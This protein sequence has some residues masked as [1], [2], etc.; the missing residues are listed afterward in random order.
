MKWENYYKIL[1]S[2]LLFKKKFKNFNV[3]ITN[4]EIKL[5]FI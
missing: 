3:S 1:L 2:Q 4:R 5:L